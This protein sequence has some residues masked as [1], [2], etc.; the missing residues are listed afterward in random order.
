MV[1]GPQ[2]DWGSAQI[3][4]FLQL[5][6]SGSPF[7]TPFEYAG[8]DYLSVR[9]GKDAPADDDLTLVVARIR[10]TGSHGEIT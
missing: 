2:P 10:A 9:A 4:A 8:F 5:G 3:R 1:D 6:D 7:R